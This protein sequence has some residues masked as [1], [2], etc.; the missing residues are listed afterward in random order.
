MIKKE[1]ILKHTNGGSDIF[2]S[3]FPEL[4]G[5]LDN[6]KLFSSP[7][8]TDPVPSA[9]FFRTADGVCLLK[10]FGGD[11]M[12]AIK[13]Y[14]CV[15]KVD[16]GE[17]CRRIA[18]E[19]NVSGEIKRSV[20]VNARYSEQPAADGEA[21]GIHVN[22][23]SM[24]REELRFLCPNAS[25][26]VCQSL[27]L[28]AVDSYTV[29]KDGRRMTF[30][31]YS[32]YPIFVRHARGIDNNGHVTTDVHKIYQPR[33]HAKEGEKNR[34]FMYQEIGRRPDSIING[35]YEIHEDIVCGN[36]KREDVTGVMCCGE[37]DAVCVKAAGYY[38]IWFNGEGH[39]ITHGEM[40]QIRSLVGKL[41]YIPDIDAP[42]KDAMMRTI[43]TFPEL[44]VVVLPDSML[45]MRG[46]QKKPCKDLRDWTEKHPSSYDFNTLL[47]TAR[48]YKMV[49]RMANGKLKFSA[50]NML[51]MLG[52]NGFCK[53][54][55]PY[56]MESMLVRIEDKKVSEVD[57][58]MIRDF[59]VEH[60]QTYS[61]EERDIVLA[62]NGL[63]NNITDLATVALDFTSATRF[64]QL[65]FCRN[66]VYAATP[67][68]VHE[69]A[70]GDGYVWKD[71]V[72]DHVV[73]LLGPLFTFDREPGYD[74]DNQPLYN[75]TPVEGAHSN[76]MEYVLKASMV[77]WKNPEEGISL[78]DKEKKENSRNLQAWMFNIGYMIHRYREADKAF[79]PYLMEYDRYPG[80]DANGGTGKSIF[81][82]YLLKGMGYMCVKIVADNEKWKQSQFVYQEVT[83]STDIVFY[84]ECYKGFCISSINSEITSGIQR[85][86][87]YS[88]RQSM[89]YV[90]SPKIGVVSNYDP[91]MSG[92]SS[93]RRAN[94]W[95]I[96]HF[97]HEKNAD[98]YFYETRTIADYFGMMLW[99]DNYAEE[100]WN[101]D[102]NFLMQC[103]S[104][105]LFVV[106]NFGHKIEPVKTKIEERC[107][108]S[109]TS[110]SFDNWAKN[111]YICDHNLDKQLKVADEVNSYNMYLRQQ[112]MKTVTSNSFTRHLRAW[113]KTQTGLELNPL[114]MC[115]DK[116]GRRIRYR[117][118]TYLYIRYDDGSPERDIPF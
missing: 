15:N 100:L 84:D 13:A 32:G 112:A 59:V 77:N 61:A 93:S 16:W 8:R 50:D 46:D 102:V 30:H 1:E 3:L 37:R 82:E 90:N 92:G 97:F 108:D 116:Q 71:K 65:F 104:F 107:L 7:F 75:I 64:T 26:S 56:S 2:A 53:W 113:V 44:L 94:L 42:G 55:A 115:T 39:V 117:N 110:A 31:S 80:A 51:F 12:N 106:K 25:E 67:D 87:K 54:K 89:S 28:E 101:E 118:V 9:H 105:Y 86:A 114:D 96:S 74:D 52:L 38:P 103:E 4:S 23:R 34:K 24:T 45:K 14:T 70:G 49:V 69:V 111:H 63:K 29:V 66:A 98:S 33:Y 22:T 48:S 99:D 18:V 6:G 83:P 19:F 57:K 43:T 35:L 60:I 91:D 40:S 85:E 20:S 81:Y 21:S 88:K 58:G 95:P 109:N 68:G 11:T 36:V 17:A 5:F 41:Y 78:T 76:A 79:A 27:G 62:S 72:I 47:K 10:D 73:T